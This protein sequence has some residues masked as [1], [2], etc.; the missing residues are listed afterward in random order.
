MDYQTKQRLE[1]IETWLINLTHRC[2]CVVGTKFLDDL[3]TEIETL[4]KEQVVEDD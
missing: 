4:R 2:V 3:V 1:L